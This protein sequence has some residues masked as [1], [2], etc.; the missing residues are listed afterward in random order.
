MQTKALKI[1]IFIITIILGISFLCLNIYGLFGNTLPWELDYTNLQNL[2][3]SLNNEYLHSSTRLLI[4][5]I[6]TFLYYMFLSP[7]SFI[8]NIFV[9]FFLFF[10]ILTEYPT[11]EKIL[12]DKYMLVFG[13]NT[14][15]GIYLTG[16]FMSAFSIIGY[17][18]FY[19]NHEKT[20]IWRYAILSIILSITL[21]VILPK[22]PVKLVF[23]DPKILILTSA[24][25][26]I[27]ALYCIIH[28]TTF[29]PGLH[30]VK[31]GFMLLLTLNIYLKTAFFGSITDIISTIILFISTTTAFI[32]FKTNNSTL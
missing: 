24:I 8:E 6:F 32:V 5:V 30:T 12:L 25:Y 16:I 2:N 20:A 11:T 27:A 13:I 14:G 19:Q 3:L 17:G 7:S 28:I 29:T 23:N 1:F 26:F 31:Q 21:S 15:T 22:S 9:P 4:T 18:L 10:S